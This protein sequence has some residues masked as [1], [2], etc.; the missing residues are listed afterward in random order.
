MIVAAEM[1]G[2][3]D[4]AEK[5]TANLKML[6]SQMNERFKRSADALAD[7]YNSYMTKALPAPQ[8]LPI[9]IKVIFAAH[10]TQNLDNLQ[11]E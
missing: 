9:R 3:K 2:N 6:E 5:L 1:A 7:S 10:V 8:F 11:I 4:E